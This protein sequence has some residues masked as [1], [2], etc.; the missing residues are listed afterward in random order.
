MNAD[1]QRTFRSLSVFVG[2]CTLQAA[3][4]AIEP[5]TSLDMLN[6]LVNKSLLRQTETDGEPRLTML[7]TIREFGLEQVDS[8]A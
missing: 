1:E 3:L 8:H 2:G 7:E 4:T 6:S 5:P